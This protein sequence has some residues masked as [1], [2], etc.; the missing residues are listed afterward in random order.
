MCIKLSLID[1]KI[2]GVEESELLFL[3]RFLYGLCDTGGYWAIAL[4]DSVMNDL[5]MRPTVG[6]PALYTKSQDRKKIGMSG[7]YVDDSLN[8]GTPEF[9][10]MTESRLQRFESKKFICD[11]FAFYGA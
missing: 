2:F 10:L 7:L 1:R 6:D 3:D 11:K 8:D 5:G 9:E 4:D